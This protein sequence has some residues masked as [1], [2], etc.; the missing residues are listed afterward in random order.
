MYDFVS[1]SKMSFSNIQNFVP[2]YKDT[3]FVSNFYYRQ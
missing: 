3:N 1:I 2:Y